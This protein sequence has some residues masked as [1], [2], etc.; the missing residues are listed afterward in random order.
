MQTV[1]FVCVVCLRKTIIQTLRP[2][3]S[4]RRALRA[5]L[6]RYQTS[7]PVRSTN[8]VVAPEKPGITGTVATI[9]RFLCNWRVETTELLRDNFAAARGQISPP[10]F[11]AYLESLDIDSRKDGEVYHNGRVVPGRHDYGRLFHFVGSLNKT[12]DFPVI[13][14]AD[15]FKV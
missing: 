7:P 5:L 11:L 4:S 13:V 10:K 15:G 2:S 3:L 1:A 14:M 8:P 12:G 9:D 6:V